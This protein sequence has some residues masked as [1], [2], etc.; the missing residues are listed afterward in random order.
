[1][2]TNTKEIKMTR[3]R[4][5][6]M[7]IVGGAPRGTRA[8]RRECPQSYGMRSEGHPGVAYWPAFSV[9]WKMCGLLQ[10]TEQICLP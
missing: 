7:R 4:L 2:L 9:P 10:A 6:Q 5:K 3:A 1:M 8:K